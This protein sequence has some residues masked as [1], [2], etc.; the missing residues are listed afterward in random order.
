MEIFSKIGLHQRHSQTYKITQEIYNLLAD[1]LSPDV[2]EWLRTETN[3]L[4]KSI[5]LFM[6]LISACMLIVLPNSLNV[7]SLEYLL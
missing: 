6:L 3:S 7:S 5:R 4:H 1:D 2:R